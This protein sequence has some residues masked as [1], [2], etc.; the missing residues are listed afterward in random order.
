MKKKVGRNL[1]DVA[2]FDRFV[3]WI[4]GRRCIN[5]WILAAGLVLGDPANAFVSDLRLDGGDRR[6]ACG[7]RPADS[8]RLHLHFNLHLHSL[9]LKR[10][11]VKVKV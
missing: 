2:N 5:I 3:R 4:G 8:V 1:D 9:R 10:V 6:R 7:P 11:Q